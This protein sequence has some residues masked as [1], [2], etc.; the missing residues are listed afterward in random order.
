MAITFF[1][2]A[3]VVLL[4]GTFAVCVLIAII[5]KRP[6]IAAI[7]GLAILMLIG[8]AVGSL[9]VTRSVS[10]SPPSALV[11]PGMNTYPDM[12][13]SP[14]DVPAPHFAPIGGERTTH[15]RFTAFAIFP[16][17][18]IAAVIGLIVALTSRSNQENRGRWWPALVVLIPMGALACFGLVFG[19]KESHRVH[20]PVIEPMVQDWIDPHAAVR[21]EAAA[22]AEFERVQREVMRL[23]AAQKRASE[24]AEQ[25]RAE[26]MR[27]AAELTTKLQRQFATMDINQ[28]IEV[29]Q[30]PKIELAEYA[31]QT[32]DAAAPPPAAAEA[33]APPVAAENPTAALPSADGAPP[34]SPESPASAPAE[35]PSAAVAEAAEDS[36]S[37][38][39]AVEAEPGDAPLVA[40]KPNGEEAKP[41]PKWVNDRPGMVGQDWHEV[42]ATDEYATAE[43]CHQAMDVYLMLKTAER[44]Q[45]LAGYPYVDHSRPSLTFRQGTV[46]GDGQVRMVRGEPFT[47]DSR[48]NLLRKMGIGIDEIRRSVVREEHLASR[49]SRRAFDT[50]YRKYTLAQFTPWFDRQLRQHWDSYQRIER[51]EIVGGGAGF[52][53]G[54]LGLVFGLLKVDTWT[55][56]YYSK[57]LFIGVPAAIIGVIFI[58]V[59]WNEVHF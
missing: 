58:L 54:L 27:R 43:E 33:P 28:L 52:V 5:T 6:A 29:F 16:L 25:A 19:L 32:G 20:A 41:L 18:V 56:G 31:Q 36:K 50:M 53:L 49:D 4:L 45:T 8:L 55:K 1:L 34:N 40:A 17:L 30:A 44:V 57:R 11:T 26:S 51:F 24:K 37:S 9:F 42:L 35:D 22:R 14:L 39:V 7:T 15:F 12:H 21:A 38:S 46:L 10:H 48:L 47:I 13:I 59:V 2:I 3:V 23:A